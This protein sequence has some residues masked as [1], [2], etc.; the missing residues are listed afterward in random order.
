MVTH[1]AK[2]SFFYHIYPLG[3]CGAP[4]RNDLQAPPLARLEKVSPWID[5]LRRLGVNALYLGPLFESTAHGY[6]T[7]DYYRLDRRLGTND[8]LTA[9]VA[10][11]HAAGIRVIFDGVFHHVGRDF[12]AFRDVQ[13]QGEQSPYA[14][15]FAGL[16]FGQQS[17]YGDPFIY[18]GWNGALDLVKLKLGHPDVRKHLLDAV[19]TWI[20]EFDIDGLRLDVAD[21]VA[22]PFLKELAT[23]CRA[24]RSDFWLMGEV[25]HGDYR[26]WAKPGVL[27]SVT[28]YEC[29]KGLFS[30]HV[31]KNYFEIAYALDRQFGPNGIYRDL[32]LYSFADN[33]DVD[34]VA[35]SLKESR[36]LYPLYCLLLTMPGVPSVYYGSEFG[37]EGKRGAHDDSVLRPC[38]ELDE[39]MANGPQPA[40]VDAIA[41]LAT[42]RHELPALRHGDYQQLAVAH[43]QLAFARTTPEQRVVV[44][45]NA[46]EQPAT[47]KFDVPGGHGRKLVD[48]LEPGKE[49]PTP[50][51][52]ASITNVPPGWA[53]VLVVE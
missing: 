51:G 50:R 22:M 5:H 26:R 40:L 41:R 17:P 16:K 21:Q 44:V 1:W 49:Y 37:V 3:F 45:V 39:L 33:H 4:P 43:E 38:L 30:S 47:V 27:D 11:L 36:H 14:S 42:L 25:I 13:Q 32:P 20:R 18:D 35:S 9:L 23:T 24:Q 2:D 28:N 52:K 53:R 15:W 10:E 48:R 46:S 29:Y 19:V 12:W 7:A 31:D 34:R 6:D 8:T